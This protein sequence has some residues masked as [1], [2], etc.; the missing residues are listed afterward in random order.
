[1]LYREAGQF[2]THLRRGRS[3]LPD[4]PG[5]HR[6]SRVLLARRVRRRA[7]H[8][9]RRTVFSA[10][11]I[12]FLILALAALG[13]NILTGYAGQLSLG[14]G[15]VHGG[16]RLRVVQLRCCA[17]RG[18][19]LLVAFVVGGLCAAAVG[20][21]FGLPSLRIRGFYLAVATLAAQFFVLWC[22][23]N[24]SAGSRTTARRAS[25]PRSAMVILGFAFDTLAGQVPARAV[26]RRADGARGEE[27]DAQR[28]RA[29]RGW[30]CATWTSRPR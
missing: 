25:S 21:V 5:P 11:L 17:F 19:P 7:A 4:P 8:R 18:I 29:G 16:R 1:M 23:T 26:D 24:A 27:H 22:L 13:L 6:R 10:I 14:T 30:R 3:D 28:D 9:R 12:P 2:K 15:G 20:I